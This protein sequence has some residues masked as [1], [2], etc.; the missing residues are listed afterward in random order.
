VNDYTTKDIA[1]LVYDIL[2]QI[3]DKNEEK[4]EAVLQT[5]T[6]ESIFP[7]RVISTP[8]ES[9]VKTENAVPVRKTFQI[10]IEHWTSKQIDSMEMTN[11]TDIALRQKNFIR[12]NTSPILW[13][14]ITKKYRLITTYEVRYNAITNAL[15]FIR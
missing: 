4:T 12:T 11:N 14:E 5:P 8:L 7:C 15:E 2:S 1:G 10:S 9:V 6:T 13:D 3:K